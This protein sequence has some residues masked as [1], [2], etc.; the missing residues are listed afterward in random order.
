MKTGNQQVCGKQIPGK[1]PTNLKNQLRIAHPKVYAALEKEETERKSKAEKEFEKKAASLKVSHQLTL[2][3]SLKTGQT[4]EKSSWR[5]AEITKKPA[6]FVGSSNVPYNIV[7]NLEF[8]DLLATL[9]N[10]YSTPSSTLIVKEVQK[11]LIEL[12]ARIG[13]F[14]HEA[15]KIS[16]CADVRSKK[17]LTSS[18]LGITAHFFSRK[19]HHRHC[20]TLAV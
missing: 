17:G 6:I 1:Y 10:R 18:Y 16:I 8:R 12:K 13:T 5:H 9:D 11:V 14:L 15:R 7:E 20:A 2:A 19:D 3:E 4:Y